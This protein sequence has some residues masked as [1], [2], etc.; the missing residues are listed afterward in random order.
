MFNKTPRREKTVKVNENRLEESPDGRD[1]LVK[2]RGNF[3]TWIY[4]LKCCIT[5]L[6]ATENWPSFFIVVW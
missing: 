3:A 2:G 6:K 5:D 1:S 4:F